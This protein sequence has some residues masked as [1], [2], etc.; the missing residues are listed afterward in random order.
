[1]LCFPES[2]NWANL[3]TVSHTFIPRVFQS[4]LHRALHCS[5]WGPNPGA[6]CPA[7]VCA[8]GWGLAPW[9]AEG[10]WGVS[11]AAVIGKG[12]VVIFIFQ[13][14]CVKVLVTVGTSAQRMQGGA[15]AAARNGGRAGSTVLTET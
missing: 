10:G 6:C 8:C 5:P 2:Q 7:V 4:V 9:R 13:T 1:M 12:A 15:G 3:A 14:V 11:V